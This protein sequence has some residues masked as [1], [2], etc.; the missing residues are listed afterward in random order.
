MYYTITQEEEKEYIALYH[1]VQAIG[2]TCLANQLR[3]RRTLSALAC[4]A[5]FLEATTDLYRVLVLCRASIHFVLVQRWPFID[6]SKS[7]P[8]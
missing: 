1:M 3:Y 7:L 5:L 4:F 6:D 2:F 8:A